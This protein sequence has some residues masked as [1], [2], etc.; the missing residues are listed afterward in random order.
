MR[1]MGKKEKGRQKE[2]VTV[3]GLDRAEQYNGIYCVGAPILDRNAYP[4]AAIW[5]TGPSENITAADIPKIGID[6]KS[7]A[8]RI[9]SILGFDATVPRE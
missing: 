1:A 7:A 6:F 3:P 9:S 5:I 8:L 4:I 2:L